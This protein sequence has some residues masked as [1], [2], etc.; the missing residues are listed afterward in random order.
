MDSEQNHR[1]DRADA[2][3]LR[4]LA[5]VPGFAEWRGDALPDGIQRWFEHASRQQLMSAAAEAVRRLCREEG[6]S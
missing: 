1:F 3:A 5:P 6:D 4:Y 2:L